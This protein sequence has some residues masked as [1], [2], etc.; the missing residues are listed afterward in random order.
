MD[1]W[2]RAF[3]LPATL[4]CT[5]LTSCYFLLELLVI[6]ELSIWT[7]IL[8]GRPSVR[9]SV[10]YNL[11]HLKDSNSLLMHSNSTYVNYIVTPAIIMMNIQ[12]I[13]EKYLSISCVVCLVG[14][15]F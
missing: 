9:D 12:L 7:L 6:G 10:R 5:E 8:I 4:N 3:Y 13:P 14:F 11:I 15:V 1:A 2:G